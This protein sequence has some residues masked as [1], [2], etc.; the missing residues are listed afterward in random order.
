MAILISLILI[1]SMSAS[2]M[3]QPTAKA[4]SPPWTIISY[5]YL[6]VAPTPVGVGQSIAV[7]M[8]VDTALPGASIS[9][10]ASNNIRRANYQLTVT[11][12]DGT[13]SSQFLGHTS[14]TQQASNHIISLPLKS[15]P[16]LSHLTILD[17]PTFGIQALLERSQLIP[18]IFSQHPTPRKP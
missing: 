2:I 14:A 5:A 11:A 12:P 4:H 1:I 16:T 15:A 18:E 8:W 3:L 13:T 10:G 17:K 6:A 7:Y 9:P